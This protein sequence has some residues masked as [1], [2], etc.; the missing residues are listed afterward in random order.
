MEEQKNSEQI[1]TL[2]NRKNLTVTGT[3]KIVSLKPELIQLSTNQGGL[4]I[5]GQSLELIKLDNSTNR[6]EI[7][8]TI[9]EIKFV[10]EKNKESLLRKIFK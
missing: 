2:I 10:G 3:N 8:G 9:N 1:L 7:S 4:M 6:A 5:V